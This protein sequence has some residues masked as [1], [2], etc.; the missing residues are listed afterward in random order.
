MSWDEFLSAFSKIL[1]HTPLTE[2]PLDTNDL[3]KRVFFSNR[4]EVLCFIKMLNLAGPYNLRIVKVS[5]NLY[6]R[7]KRKVQM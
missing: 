7:G 3:P 4:I 1:D 2:R 6:L 5:L